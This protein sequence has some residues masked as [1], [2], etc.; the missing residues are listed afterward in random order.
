MGIIMYARKV[1]REPMGNVNLSLYNRDTCRKGLLN[2][3]QQPKTE[4]A[5]SK[6][7]P[8]IV[9]LVSYSIITCPGSQPQG[10]T[11][12]P[13]GQKQMPIKART[14]TGVSLEWMSHKG[15][16]KRCHIGCTVNSLPVITR[17]I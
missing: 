8:K 6:R 9:H 3:R 12:E 2:H 11:K 13:K 16:R 5:P 1:L 4:E 10:V 17:L 14:H 7:V 15:K